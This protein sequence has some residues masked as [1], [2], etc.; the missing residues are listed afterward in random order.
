MY[1]RTVGDNRFYVKMIG[2][3]DG[4]LMAIDTPGVQLALWVILEKKSTRGY[5][6]RNAMGGYIRVSY[7]TVWY[8]EEDRLQHCRWRGDYYNPQPSFVEPM[9]PRTRDWEN[10]PLVEEPYLKSMLLRLYLA[11]AGR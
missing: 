2:H 8:I 11:E 9:R 7:G 1:I 3:V 6:T 5:F 10:K 4:R